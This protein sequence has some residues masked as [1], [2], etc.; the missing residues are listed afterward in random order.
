MY[1]E[2]K[3]KHKKVIKRYRMM[4]KNTYRN[5]VSEDVAMDMLFDYV[6]RELDLKKEQIKKE[7]LKR[8]RTIWG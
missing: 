3:P 7:I 8:Q 6:N 4:Q 5:P 1:L 2:I